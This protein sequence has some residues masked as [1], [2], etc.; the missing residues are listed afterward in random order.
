MEGPLN[1]KTK[2]LYALNKEK[3]PWPSEC[4][5]FKKYYTEEKYRNVF[6][7]EGLEAALFKF[8][9]YSPGTRDQSYSVLDIPR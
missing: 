8:S 5:Q 6:L 4:H 7:S 3:P 1:F 2:N 9:A